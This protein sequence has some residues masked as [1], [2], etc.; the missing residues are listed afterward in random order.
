MLANLQK[1]KKSSSK[2]VKKVKKT[3]VKAKEPIMDS[4]TTSL[5]KRTRRN[6]RN[7]SNSNAIIGAKAS[8]TEEST[9]IELAQKPTKKTRTA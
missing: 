5:G 6:S 7:T 3:K 8:D 9:V 1:K 4:S 2:K